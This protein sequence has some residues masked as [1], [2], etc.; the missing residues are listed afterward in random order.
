MQRRAVQQPVDGAALPGA[1]RLVRAQHPV[2]QGGLG[3]RPADR[4][5]ER[6]RNPLQR[7]RLRDQQMHRVGLDAGAVL[8]RPVHVGREGAPHPRPASRAVLDLGVDVGHRLLE[9]DVD[10]GAPLVAAARHAAQVP[11]APPAHLGRGRRDGLHGARVGRCGG[12]LRRPLAL[13]ARPRQRRRVV[14]R[15][16]RRQARVRGGVRRAPLREHRQQHLERQQQGLEQ[17]P[18][19]ATHRAAVAQ[20]PEASLEPVELLAQRLPVNRRHPPAPRLPPPSSP[21][22]PPA[23]PPPASPGSA[24][25]SAPPCA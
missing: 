12:A 11:A 21:P 14:R 22:A 1:E 13:G 23:A 3:D 2:E 25:P 4:C 7:H 19:L 24:P 17:R 6:L 8:Q 16:R 20:F 15:L 5:R 18:A 10:P 9:H